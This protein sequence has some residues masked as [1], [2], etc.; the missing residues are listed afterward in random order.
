MLSVIYLGGQGGRFLL[1][2][3]IDEKLRL[4]V[5]SVM[6]YETIDILIDI[7]NDSMKGHITMAASITSNH[8]KDLGSGQTGNLAHNR[9]DFTPH[10]VDPGLIENNIIYVNRSLAE[11]Y[12]D[13]FGDAIDDYNRK[14]KR[15]DRKKYTRKTYFRHLFECDPDSERAGVILTSNARG[16]YEIKSFCEELF[17]VGDCMEFGHFMRDKYGNLTDKNGDPVKWNKY[18]NQYYDIN[19]NAVNDSRS[20]MPNSNAEKAKEILDV[21][22]KGGR[23]KFVEDQNGNKFLKRLDEGSSENSDLVVPPFEE[24][25]PYFHVVYA[26]MHN[27]EWHGTPHIHIDYVPVGTGYVKGPE[28][29]V[30]FERALANM[31]YPDKNTAYKE[32]RDKERAILKEVCRCYGLE[33]KTKEEERLNNR[34]KTYAVEVYK[35][36]VREG[37]AEGQRMI[38]CSKQEAQDTIDNAAIA[39]KETVERAEQEAQDILDTAKSEGK[40]IKESAQWEADEYIEGVKLTAQDITREAERQNA[41]LTFDNERLSKENQSLDN[42][43]RS[44]RIQ[45]ALL[46]DIAAKMPQKKLTPFSYFKS[47][48]YE[49]GKEQ[50]NSF[51]ECVEHI[52]RYS[53]NT[54]TSDEDKKAAEA[55]RKRYEQL[56]K[57]AEQR[58]QRQAEIRAD[59]ISRQLREQL[60]HEMD[61]Y[62]KLRENENKYILSMANKVIETLSPTYRKQ[63]MDSR[64]KQL[65]SALRSVKSSEYSINHFDYSICPE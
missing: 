12:D 40:A 35:Q 36:A 11:V 4:F 48:K 34:G 55:E 64:K 1:A 21:F 65:I 54:L 19:G 59:Q 23:F 26:A 38:E 6:A 58:I 57:E 5:N 9:R 43:I 16:K 29:Q 41:A 50:Y 24:R 27:D 60:Q 31:G 10:N 49:M 14:Q 45:I 61:K 62:T 8:N 52:K 46:A 15:K 51:M 18:N 42:D 32:W 53:N 33:T 2:P 44:K 25:N 37:T 56:N 22:F 28:K 13:A 39:A 47:E 7:N 17:Q 20:L 63:D 30:G 3:T